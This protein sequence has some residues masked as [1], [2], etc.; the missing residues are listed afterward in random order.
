MQT[1]KRIFALLSLALLLCALLVPFI[2]AAVGR[3]DDVA[4][5]FGIVSGFLS[6]LFGALGWSERIARIVTASL[7][8]LLLVGGAGALMVVTRLKVKREAEMRGQMETVKQK[9]EEL[10]RQYQPRESS[11]GN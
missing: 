5:G 7:L 2:I 9:Q 4:L 11:D 10:R 8:L 3:N 1:D 6:L